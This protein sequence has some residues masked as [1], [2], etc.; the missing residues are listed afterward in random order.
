MEG[1][2]RPRFFKV[3]VG[4]FAR[5]IEIPRGF[6]C[7]IPEER[8][9]TSAATVASS[10]K[11]LLKNA[12]GK[13]WPVELEE[14]DGRVFLTTGWSK[15]VKGNCL[16]EGEFLV[17]E[18]DGNMH[19]RVSVF[20]VNAVEKAVW[21]SGSG[22]QATGN[23]GEQP[24]YIF[25]SSKKGHGGDE[26]TETTVTTQR[27]TQGDEH[28][29]SQDTI[30]F[31]DLHEVGCSKDELETCLSQ[32]EPME[33]GKAKAI[34]EAMRTLHVDKLAVELFC[35]TLC[36]YKWKVEAAA[37]DLNICRGK[38]NILE[39][40]MKQKLVLQFD[41]IKRQLQRFF[42]PDDDSERIKKNNLEGPNLSNQ[43][44]QRDLTVPP[45]KRRLVDENEPCDLSHK[46]KRKI[47]KLQQGSPQTQTPRRSPRLAHLNNTRNS[48]NNVLKKRAEVLKPPPATII[49]VKDRGHKSCSLHKKPYNALK[50]T[51]G[52][53]SQ[54]LRKLDSPRCEVGV[55]KEHEHDQGE[56]RKML[57]H[58][59]DRKNSKEQMEINAVETSDSFMSTDCIESPPNN[60]G[61]TA[62]SRTSELSFTWKHPQHVNPLEK[63]LLDIQRDN[64]VKTIASIQ[65]IIR[66]DPSDVLSADT[67]EAAVRIGILKCDSCLQDRNAQK[68]V[69]ALLEYAKKVK[70]KNNFSIE[71]RKEEFSAKLQDL[72]KWQLKEL[73]T[74]YTSLESD[75]KKASTDSTIFFSTLEEHRKKL[76]A[77]K[78][79]IKDNQQD[80]MIEDEIQKLAHKVAEHETIYQKSII[81]KV[82]V[83]M[84]LK[85]YQ[86]TLGDVKER[87]ASTEPGSVDVEALV[88]IEMD[89]MSKEI[90]LSKG[91]LLNINFE[92]E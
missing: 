68:I 10:A 71:M 54:D 48:T 7:H 63:I 45:V 70:E 79:G 92:K 72:L 2:R 44:L 81:E 21:P 58:S 15:F 30:G 28:I 55:S 29:S 31:L 69:N 73:E 59:D 5:R 32:K 16:G 80:L 64:F 38:L 35:A 85:N 66:D 87:L 82:R 53:L 18:Y 86:Q 39:Q 84:D 4:D 57:D 51:T 90:Q 83:K 52:S 50:T 27:S 14:I 60:S 62:Y 36:L 78:D 47:V 88:K 75:Y 74:A 42:P 76:H 20:G 37:E 6:L 22:A 41:F 17:V 49:Q 34:A 26:L 65:K 12:E 24:C 9:R 67:I 23:L 91:I 3:L 56:T 40:S 61:L 33:D 8:R 19:F 13:T 25:P 46:Q 11:A 43:P 1:Q 77:V 89:N